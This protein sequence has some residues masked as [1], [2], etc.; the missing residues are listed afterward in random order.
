MDMK[1][2][3]PALLLIGLGISAC[4]GGGGSGSGDD[5]DA[6]IAYSGSTAPATVTAGNARALADGG[7]GG[8]NQA[9]AADSANGASA[10]A[11]RGAASEWNLAAA[12]VSQLELGAATQQ[13]AG[14]RSL[15]ICDSGSAELEQN[16]EG[17]EGTVE[18]RN[19]R[20]SGGNGVVLNGAASF[21]ASLSGSTVTSLLMR[22]VNFSVRYQ[23]D[24]QTLNMTIACKGSPL[25]CR[26][27]SDF[28]GLDG[29]VYRVELDLVVNIAAS[30]FDVDAVVYHPQHGYY[31]IDAS[32]TYGKCAGG[33]PNAG[34]ITLSGAGGSEAVVVFDD[35]DQFTVTHLG[36]PVTYFWAD[37]R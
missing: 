19:C 11:S 35:C 27:F 37:I 15:S 22:F 3:L 1:R 24:T 14:T 33:V 31:T 13:R 17:T 30:S 21:V 8:A 9:V 29:K 20:V 5:G 12:V 6:R 2:L 16:S 4:G 34:S 18:Y 36:V 23:G 10:V 25:K 28:V 7:T 32:V 26:A